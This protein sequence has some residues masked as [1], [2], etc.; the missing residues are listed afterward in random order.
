MKLRH[1][2]LLLTLLCGIAT[3]DVL[4]SP[5]VATA[6]TPGTQPMAVVVPP[7]VI[8]LLWEQECITNKVEAT[9]DFQNWTVITNLLAA[10]SNS[11]PIEMTQPYQFFRVSANLSTGQISSVTITN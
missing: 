7:P 2:I 11:V 3:A 4:Q 8:H 5:R 6:T 9:T 1:S 10:P